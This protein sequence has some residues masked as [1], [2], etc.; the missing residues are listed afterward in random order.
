[1]M[2]PRREANHKLQV[3]QSNYNLL[4]SREAAGTSHYLPLVCQQMLQGSFPIAAIHSNRSIFSDQMI[5]VRMVWTFTGRGG[6]EQLQA[7]FRDA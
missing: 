3:K 4:S 5:G 2:K 7:K 6:T 1:M